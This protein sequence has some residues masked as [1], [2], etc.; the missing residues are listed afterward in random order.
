MRIVII[1]AGKI[2]ITLTEYL[3]GEGHN[4]TV[5]DID[6]D[7]I[8]NLNDK[9]DVM[10]FYGNGVNYTTLKD[11]GVNH[12]DLVIATTSSDEINMLCCIVAKKIGAKKTIARIRDPEYSKQF[13][14]LTDELGFDMVVNPEFEAAIEIARILRFP[15]AI[16]IDTFAK[17]RVEMAEFKI[18]ED[19]IFIGKRVS[20]IQKKYNIKILICAV[21][22]EEDVYI[23]DGDFMLA[24]KDYI[25]FTAQHS[26][27]A[28]FFKL[29]G[30]YKQ[31]VKNVII[32][33]GGRIAYYLVSFLT[34]TGV[35]IK[36]IENDKERCIEL[37]EKFQKS[38]I[39]HGDGTDQS[40][41]IEEHIEGSD[42]CVAITGIDE[43]NIIIS[44]YAKKHHVGKVITKI[45]K[46]SL[47]EMLENIGL[48]SII[49][50][51][52]ITANHIISYV[53]AMNNTD[54][55]GVQ[56]LYKLVGGRVEALEFYISKKNELLNV[57]LSELNLKRNLLIS[58]IIRENKIIFPRG[59]DVIKLYDN[60]IVVTTNKNLHSFGDII[61]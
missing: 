5:I 35:S 37:S 48:D 15:A 14:F 31:R 32:I 8:E 49:S 40:L 36:I 18:P 34:E 58:C 44:M 41:L 57:P 19:S 27:I 51:R 6:K 39:I 60:I 24:E 26:E 22:R 45:S 29:I 7:V 54:G 25:Y 33:G 1:G 2:G 16:K 10:G 17:G 42:A 20:E 38:E 9:Y 52:I 12:S 28:S 30:E 4:L 46:T 59:D 55:G 3:S 21:Q 43:E 23:P 56:T 47:V 11:A 61:K 53:R 50:P 13:S